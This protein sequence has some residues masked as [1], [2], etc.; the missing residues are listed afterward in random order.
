[1]YQI[2]EEKLQK[3]LDDVLNSNMN[4]D[5]SFFSIVHSYLKLQWLW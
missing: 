4:F 1:M 2:N 5:F 3:G